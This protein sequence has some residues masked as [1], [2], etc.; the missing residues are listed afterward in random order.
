MGN[1]D[2]CVTILMAEDDDG[3]ALLA[4]E[5]FELMGMRNPVMRFKN[6]KEIWDF[7]SGA[8]A[9]PE[10]GRNCLLLLDIRMPGDGR[11]RGAPAHKNRHA[12]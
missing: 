10:A 3:H 11:H 2:D 8:G 1:A 9:G 5:R 6:G 12:P 4:Q 7:L